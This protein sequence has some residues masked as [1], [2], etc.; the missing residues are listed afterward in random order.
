MF[1]IAARRYKHLHNEIRMTTKYCPSCNAVK[2]VDQFGKHKGR[3]FNLADSCKECRN[4]KMV[5]K[6]HGITQ[7]Q[8]ESMFLAQNYECAICHIHQNYLE[9]Q[10]SVDHCHSTGVIRGLLCSEC[11][12]MLGKA[13]DSVLI[14]ES[15]IQYLLNAP[16]QPNKGYK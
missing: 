9:N 11:N 13:R 16:K 10:L 8:L 15:A 4:H 12:L 3:K 2:S 14:L 1:K 7:E 5:L 6:R